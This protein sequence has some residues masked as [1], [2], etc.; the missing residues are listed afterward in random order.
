MFEFKD[1]SLLKLEDNY[2]RDYKCFLALDAPVKLPKLKNK[3]YKD[4][5][6]SD[7]PLI[8]GL[9]ILNFS[10]LD[11]I[12]KV[13]DRKMLPKSYNFEKIKGQIS[14]SKY[15]SV[16]YNRALK[17]RRRVYM[18]SRP[19]LTKLEVISKILNTK[20][21]NL[22]IPED[23]LE[24]TREGL[25]TRVVRNTFCCNSEVD[26]HELILSYLS[27]MYPSDLETFPRF[28]WHQV[29]H[30]L[31]DEEIQLTRHEEPIEV[32]SDLDKM[33][34]EIIDLSVNPY[35]TSGYYIKKYSGVPTRLK[36]IHCE[37]ETRKRLPRIDIT[38]KEHMMQSISVVADHFELNSESLE[39]YLTDLEEEYLESLEEKPPDESGNEFLECPVCE[40]VPRGFY[41]KF[42]TPYKV[43][44]LHLNDAQNTASQDY[45]NYLMGGI[46]LMFSDSAKEIE[47]K[48][49]YYNPLDTESYVSIFDLETEDDVGL[50]FSFGDD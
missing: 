22:A 37:L 10:I 48:V 11:E 49:Q 7:D 25:I 45:V 20:R 24:F 14:L 46:R 47:E 38:L 4:V 39:L 3:K 41:D 40:Q 6:I 33:G 31:L 19:T 18:S 30:S 29:F 28:K 1:E 2:H 42:E 50:G 36:F 12:S 16:Y 35:L 5:K 34:Q 17:T 15:A 32:L 9:K 21:S 43:C 13:V 8:G 23:L 27:S 26:S 44:D